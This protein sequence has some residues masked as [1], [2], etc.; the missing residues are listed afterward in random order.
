MMFSLISVRSQ[1][2][3]KQFQKKKGKENWDCT[4][5][6]KANLPADSF[7][8]KTLPKVT[9]YIFGQQVLCSMFSE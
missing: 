2:V 5:P 8:M 9:F 6:S 4:D 3:A 1:N 7:I